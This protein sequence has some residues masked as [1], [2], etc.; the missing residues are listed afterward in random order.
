MI[1]ILLFGQ[2]RK[3]RAHTLRRAGKGPRRWIPIDQL[4]QGKLFNPELQP[5][6]G[7]K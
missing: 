4:F 3:K 2:F 6:L 7:W 5:P 1:D